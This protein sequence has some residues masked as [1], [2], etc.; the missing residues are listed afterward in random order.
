MEESEMRAHLASVIPLL[1][2]LSLAA[3][4]GR[5]GGPKSYLCQS[6]IRP[7]KATAPT[8]YVSP[9]FPSNGDRMAVSKAWD[10]YILGKYAPDQLPELEDHWLSPH[11]SPGN[12]GGLQDIHDRA[13]NGSAVEEKWTYTPETGSARAPEAASAGAAAAAGAAAGQTGNFLSF[14]FGIS[15]NTLYIS[16]PFDSGVSQ[17]QRL[18]DGTTETNEFQE[19]LT[20]RYDGV[21]PDAISASGCHFVASAAEAESRKRAV[22]AQLQRPGTSIVDVNWK[23]APAASGPGRSDALSGKVLCVSTNERGTV[24]FSNVDAPSASVQSS[25]SNWERQF[26]QFLTQR[27]SF[28]GRIYCNL[29]SDR[30][31]NARMQG[32]REGEN[33]VV[34][35][36]WKVGASAS[37]APGRSNTTAE[38]DDDRPRP[39]KSPTAQPA[40]LQARNV[41]IKEVPAASAACEGNRMM[42]G[43]FDCHCVQGRIYDFRI[44]HPEDT[45]SSTPQP[46]ARLL[47]GNEVAYGTCVT[48]WK[49]KM[50]AKSEAM[51]HRLNPT[52]AECAANKLVALLHEKA[53]PSRASEVFDEALHACSK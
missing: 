8:T 41:A 2:P 42:A 25:E 18:V 20:G 47:T 26:T 34:D 6:T 51:S 50:W 46:I 39:Q 7:P 33:K 36:G 45:V 44:S 38:A 23:Y 32:A 29:D 11:C 19:Y 31:L 13:L 28:K 3:G 16:Q 9:V 4:Q 15:Q 27:Y 10:K 48:E 5:S 24:Y 12:P 43:E 14:C 1:L 37:V 49:V 22:V 52:A 30:R 53:A 35:A 17:T 40:S 21:N